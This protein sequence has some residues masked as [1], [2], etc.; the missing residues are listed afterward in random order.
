MALR[1]FVLL[2]ILLN[3]AFLAW[4]RH[5]SVA[6]VSTETHLMQQ[7]INPGAIRLLSA[8]Q[9]GS[10]TVKTACM[11][12]GGFSPEMAARA[13]ES[14]GKLL[15]GVRF[16]SRRVDEP[17]TWWVY[18]LPQPDRQRAQQ[19]VA[20]LKR[21]GVEEFFIVQDESKFRFAVSLGIFRTQEAAK[22]K[23]EQLRE[24]GVRTAQVG[25]R[26]A[27]MQMTYYQLRDLP[28]GANAQL[29]ELRQDF[30]GT[31]LKPCGN[32]VPV[33]HVPLAKS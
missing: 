5:F 11:E 33:T 26:E 18:M 16:T 30:A 29:A 24:K 1:P 32:A 8:Q 12:W 27:Q 14:L 7:Q 17:A 20:E 4:S 23:L 22:N 28:E 2:L 15:P 10:L 19:K 13:E 6:S 9:A 3:V 21:L 31:E 25:P